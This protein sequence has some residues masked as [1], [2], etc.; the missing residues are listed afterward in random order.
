[1]RKK[2]FTLIEIIVCVVLIAVI[3]T[4]SVVSVSK[5]MNSNGEKNILENNTSNFKDALEVYLSEHTEIIKNVNNNA[6]A[7]V[8]SL[9]LLKN[10]GLISKDLDID[11][12]NNYFTLSNAILMPPDGSVDECADQIEIKTFASWEL[13]DKSTEVI[14]ICPREIDEETENPQDEVDELLERIESLELSLSLLD[15]GGKNYILFDVN[16][17]PNDITSWPDGNN[18]DLWAIIKANTVD[19]ELKLLYNQ[20]LI[21]DNSK[22]YESEGII[23]SSTAL[24]DTF[25]SRNSLKDRYK[26]TMDNSRGF[27]LKVP[28]DGIDVET[29]LGV[30]E[31][32]HVKVKYK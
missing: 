24:C 30:D 16:S 2:G 22:G 11:Y 9:E 3:G 1:M 28:I 10:E 17:K 6:K 25:Y 26:L 4:V 32:M 21:T 27:K 14:Y 31:K 18:Q 7:A 19:K 29:K 20:N 12:K 8:V 5:V 15:L 23:Y 13:D